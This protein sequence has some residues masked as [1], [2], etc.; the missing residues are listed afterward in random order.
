VQSG[1]H[2]ETVAARNPA[3]D[4][5]YIDFAVGVAGV[6]NAIR[7]L[8]HMFDRQRGL[9]AD[10]T[11]ILCVVDEARRI[12]LR[13]ERGALRLVDEGEPAVTAR[14]PLAAWMALL[15]H[16]AAGSAVVPDDLVVTGDPAVFDALLRSL[17]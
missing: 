16:A 6:D 1:T 2:A 13:V 4:V 9:V 15:T 3:K 7:G 10:G 14:G 11:T 12:L 17:R 5:R 8:Q